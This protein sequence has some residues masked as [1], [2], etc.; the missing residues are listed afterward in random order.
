[1]VEGRSGINRRNAVA[2]PVYFSRLDDDSIDCTTE[3]QSSKRYEFQLQGAI[4]SHHPR[5]P[6]GSAWPQCAGLLG[7]VDVMHVLGVQKEIVGRSLSDEEKRCHQLFRT[8]P[9]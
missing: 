1:M 6:A 3:R 7:G 9:V 8:L 5:L 4:E 2:L